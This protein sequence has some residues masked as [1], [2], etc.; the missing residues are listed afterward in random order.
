MLGIQGMWDVQGTLNVQGVVY[1]ASNAYLPWHPGRAGHA[2]VQRARR[3]ERPRQVF[4]C[5]GLPSLAW[6]PRKIV[7][8]KR[9]WLSGHAGRPRRAGRPKHTGRLRRNGRPI[10]IGF[11]S[12][13]GVL[14]SNAIEMALR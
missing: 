2:C 5:A 8:P 3:A 4:R 6:H 10:F 13:Q 14:D 12:F 1:F 7:H 9:T 11:P